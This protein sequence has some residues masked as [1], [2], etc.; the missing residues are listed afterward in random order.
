MDPRNKDLDYI[1]PA[2][3]VQQVNRRPNTLKVP[4]KLSKAWHYYNW[5]WSFNFILAGIFICLPSILFMS[6]TVLFKGYQLMLIAA[7][8]LLLVSFSHRFLRGKG[9]SEFR[10]MMFFGSLGFA[11]VVITIV[12]FT[13]TIFTS[14]TEVQFHKI[15]RYE[16]KRH[17]GS[18]AN[19][20]DYVLE[21]ENGAF[22]DYENVRTVSGLNAI[23]R[24]GDVPGYL[25]VVSSTGIWG[26]TNIENSRYSRDSELKAP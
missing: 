2:D 21:L 16:K 1:L 5:N 7:G 23:P 11:P 12:L 4:E 26:W 8:C 14:G 17:Y 6:M 19:R 13:N 15:T 10:H 3:F 18:G 22:G 9:I 24:A 25:V 20:W